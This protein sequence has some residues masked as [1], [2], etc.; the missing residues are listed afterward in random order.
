MSLHKI[1]KQRKNLLI[2]SPSDTA[3][4]AVKRM[5]EKES[6]VVLVA[7]EKNHLVGLFAE[8]DALEN[9]L[10]KGLDANRTPLSDV[11]FTDIIKLTESATASDAI[12]TMVNGRI[13][14]LPIVTDANEIV[15]LVSLR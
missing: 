1:L 15:G 2:M 10:A 5:I 4:V 13:R 3:M 8:R 6:G 14:H 12:Q 11:M 9:V 7:D